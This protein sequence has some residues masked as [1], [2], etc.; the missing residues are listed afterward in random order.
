MQSIIDSFPE[1]DYSDKIAFYS[2]FGC[3]PYVLSTLDWNLTLKENIEKY[4][5][6]QNSIL[7][8]HIEN[9]MLSEIRQSFDVRILELIGNGKI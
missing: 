2:V 8:T 7:R 3:S 5:I 9:V 1:L 4:L 6:N